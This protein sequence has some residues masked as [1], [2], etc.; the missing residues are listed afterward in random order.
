MA[1]PLRNLRRVR[2]LE[3]RPVVALH[4]TAARQV[5]WEACEARWVCRLCV[6]AV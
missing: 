1:V 4:D 5:R 3:V 6:L 2:R